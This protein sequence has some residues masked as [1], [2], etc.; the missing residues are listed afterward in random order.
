MIFDECPSCKKEGYFLSKM[1]D[2][3]GD[4]IYN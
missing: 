1:L 2:I 3:D 4:M